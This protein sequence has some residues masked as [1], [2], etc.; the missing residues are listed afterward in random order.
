HLGESIFFARLF[1]VI[2]V[3]LGVYVASLVA[4]A[5]LPERMRIWA[6]AVIA[7]NPFVIASAIEARVYGLVFLWSALLMWLFH[8]GY[9][10]RHN[11]KARV[12]FALVAVAALY[13]QYYTGFLLPAFAAALIVHRRW[14]D[15]GVFATWM[16]FV[17][18]SFV[19]AA[20][21][22]HSEI[23]TNATN[24]A[25]SQG[26]LGNLINA[27]R[28]LVYDTLA[29]EWL[30]R[31][32]R[33]L[34]DAG[35]AILVAIILWRADKVALRQTV[36]DPATI[37]VT[38][39]I[40]FVVAVTA[41]HTPVSGRYLAAFH[42]LALITFFGLLSALPGLSSQRTTAIVASVLLLV[43]V[44]SFV[45]TYRPLAKLGDWSRVAAYITANESANQR[46]VVFDAQS[47]LPLAYYY[48]GKNLIV[49]LPHAMRFD[50]YDLHDVALHNG[51][52]V[53]HALGYPAGVASV[54]LVT[55]NGCR[56]AP[57]NFR[58]ELLDGVVSRRYRTILDREFYGSR[59]RLLRESK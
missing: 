25:T 36:G 15:L 44:G 50:R 33:L 55:S 53:A 47:A 42:L 14:R 9:L 23:A 16:V 56:R 24:F 2:A 31:T 3:A 19:P 49:A 10:G 32:P 1:S 22:V 38:A 39:L 4:S 29:L 17:G 5:Y 26:P 58:C 45:N 7:F 41:T 28:V 18:V 8:A 57:V 48:K 30:G 37:L 46:I 59:V 27:I 40:L 51:S 6:T 12:A 20:L 43:N 11:A 52:E 54:W 34:A 13:T 35:A 21:Y